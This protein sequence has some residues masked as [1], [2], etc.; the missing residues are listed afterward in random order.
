MPNK[1]INQIVSF[2]SIYSL[3]ELSVKKQYTRKI[4]LTMSEKFLPE[5][6]SYRFSCKFTFIT[7]FFFL[8]NRKQEHNLCKASRTIL[9]QFMSNSTEIYKGTF[10]SVILVIPTERKVLTLHVPSRG[11]LINKP[12][13]PNELLF[14]RGLSRTFKT[15]HFCCY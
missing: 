10:F 1:S 2:H 9:A 3:M 5:N 12:N 14:S 7:F 13:H 8:R 4:L 15:W 6:N 11:K